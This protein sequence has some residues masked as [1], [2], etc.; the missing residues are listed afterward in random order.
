VIRLSELV[1][2]KVI[3][4]KQ[5]DTPAKNLRDSVYLFE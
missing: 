4:L 2:G 5:G 3:N 1:M